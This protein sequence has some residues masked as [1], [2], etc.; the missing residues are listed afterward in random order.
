[1]APGMGSIDARASS[2]IDRLRDINYRLRELKDKLRY[3]ANDCSKD[4]CAGPV[5][6]VNDYH[7]VID[8]TYELVSILEEE[9]SR[10]TP[11]SLTAIKTRPEQPAPRY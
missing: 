7:D 9:V 4:V 1:M 11:K 8:T 6:L 3:P 2:P 10:L 5:T